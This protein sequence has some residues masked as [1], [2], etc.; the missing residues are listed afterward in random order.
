MNDLE[1]KVLAT[2]ARVTNRPVGDISMKTE[3]ASL[4]LDSLDNLE[5]LMSLEEAFGIDIDVTR[6]SRC[7]ALGDIAGV[8]FASNKITNTT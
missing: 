8:C 1:N 4:D 7:Q 3:L 2:V 6:I 5:I